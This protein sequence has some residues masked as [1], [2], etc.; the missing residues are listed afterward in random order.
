MLGVQ[1]QSG[2]RAS[3][4]L[5][6]AVELTAANCRAVYI[7]GGYAHGFQDGATHQVYVLINNPL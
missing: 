7:P 5:W 4:S 6:I 1:S 2:R 3:I